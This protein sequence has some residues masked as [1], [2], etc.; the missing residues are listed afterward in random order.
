MK[1]QGKRIFIVVVAAIALA[2]ATRV[3]P[4]TQMGAVRLAILRAGYPVSAMLSKLEY[5]GPYV[6]D[7]NDLGFYVPLTLTPYEKGTDSRLDQWNIY[8][9][10]RL[11]SARFGH[12]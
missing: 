7:P 8:K 12:G 11:Y 1:K 6:D 5:H 10:G 4:V 9:N 3:A 2:F